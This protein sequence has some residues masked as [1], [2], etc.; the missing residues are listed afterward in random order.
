MTWPYIYESLSSHN[1]PVTGWAT[2]SMLQQKRLRIEYSFSLISD[3]QHMVHGRKTESQEEVHFLKKPLHGFLVREKQTILTPYAPKELLTQP[4]C[5]NS[6]KPSYSL[7]RNCPKWWGFGQ[8]LTTPLIFILSPSLLPSQ[9]PSWKAKYTSWD[10]HIEENPGFL[11]S[12][13]LALPGQLPISNTQSLT[14]SPLLL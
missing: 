1:S 8:W 10:N 7:C 3:G 11:I 5:R 2:M 6:R 4:F 9:N 12:P 13:P 14:H